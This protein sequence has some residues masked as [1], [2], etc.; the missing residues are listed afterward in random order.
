MFIYVSY[1]FMIMI[2]LI[3]TY[4]HI[5][6]EYRENMTTQEAQQ[7]LSETYNKTVIEVNNLTVTGDVNTK[8]FNLFPSGGIMLWNNYTAPNGWVICDGKNGTPDLQDRFIL[9]ANGIPT[10]E[11]NNLIGGSNG[12]TIETTNLPSHSHTYTTA[13]TF[14]NNN[15]RT[16]T[17]AA[18]LGFV[19]AN[20]P[21]KTV[22]ILN[23]FVGKGTALT[24]TQKNAESK[25]ISNLP[26]YYVL[27]YIMKL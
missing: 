10:S 16:F 18:A 12:I 15:Y 9:G 7:T 6:S 4:K 27:T 23:K 21:H 14:A 13:A 5:S 11:T 3:L 22:G 19:N 17:A 26:K 1:F 25:P 8:K 24:S 2:L 20:Y